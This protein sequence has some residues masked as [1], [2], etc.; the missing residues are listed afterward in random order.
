MTTPTIFDTCDPRDDVLSGAIADADFAA[1]LASVIAGTAGPEYRDPA[2]FFADTYPTRGLKD[3]LANVCGRL[4]RAGEDVGPIIRLNTAYG[5]GKTHGLI[6][7]AHLATGIANVPNIA[8]FVDEDRVPRQRIRIAAFDG[9]N[10]DPSNGRA[11]AADVLAYT[12]WGEIAYAL[13]GREGYERVRRSDEKQIAPGAETLRELFGEEPSIVLLD[14]LAVYLRKVRGISDSPPQLAAFLTSLFKAVE[15]SPQ[16]VLVYTLAIGKDG[17]ATDAYSE[18]HQHIADQLAEVESISARK[19]T[20]LDPTEEDETVQVLRRRLFKR[21]D[22]AGMRSAIEAYRKSWTANRESL[23]SEATHPKTVEA[24]QESYPLHP[25]VLETLTGKTATLGNFQRVRGMLRLLA[26]TIAHLWAEKPADARALHLHHVNPGYEPIRQ[27]IVTRLGQSAYLPAIRRD[28]AEAEGRALAEA[29]DAEHHTGLPPYATYVARTI[30]LHTLAFNERLK[31]LAPEQ[32][33]YSILSPTTDV[34]FIEEA[35]KRFI[36][37][38]AFLDDRPGAPMRFLAEANLR[39]IIRGEERNVDASEARAQLDD[40]IKTIFGGKT[41]DTIPFASGPFDVPDEIGDGRPKLALLH[42]DAINVG[43]TVDVV[44]ELIAQIYERKGAE[45]QALRSLRNHL[46]FVVAD[47]SHKTEMQRRARERLALQALKKPERLLDLAEHQQ[48]KVRELE[49]KSEHD[50]AIAIQQ[51]YRHLFYP[52]RN[53]IGTST[54]D[55]AHSALDM[56][57][58]S[59]TPGAGQDEIVRALRDQTKL[60]LSED[61]PDS[62]A[63]VRDRTTL[64]R[65]QITT[66]ALRDEFRK[67]PTLPI[68]IG[69]DIFRRGVL[70][71]VEQGEYVYRRGDL[72]FGPGDPTVS[73]EIDE[74]SVVFTMAFAK[75]TDIWPR[76]E[77]AEPTPSRPS[78]GTQ[79][80][81]PEPEAAPETPGSAEAQQAAGGAPKWS[82]EGILKEALVKLWELA[83]SKGIQALSR[84]EIRTFESSDGFALLGAVG[85]V[86]GAQKTVVLEGGYETTD[87]GTFEIKFQ[88]RVPDA[89]PVREFLQ[90]QLRAAKTKDIEIRFV[91]EFS[92]GLKLNGEAPENL[93]ERLSKFAGGAA[94]VSATGEARNE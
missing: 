55:L 47:E 18:E 91:L 37:D 5:G 65:G 40:R 49:A 4:S 19:A 29:I 58:A 24:F 17:V 15:G 92:D 94:H 75:N 86:P 26:R 82:T 51:C 56:H 36:A 28:I 13:A 3:L 10:A 7:L 14:E 52:S 73:I 21:I 81:P 2:R 63:Y 38:S 76:P 25:E 50:L 54:V 90:P 20:V 53:R 34:S 23:S 46:V 70:R 43:T 66:L 57:S 41:F 33:R 84:V 42:Y 39:Q 22:D 8:E 80:T 68:L 61:E 12:P 88:G 62:P 48:D 67:D 27:E 87:D 44:P 93:T 31:G 30:F 79:Q 72:L 16:A 9:E 45:G 69:D 11:M 77:P 60:R 78:G 74:Q 83:R 85:A 35:R 6:A 1:D 89:E 71:G 64:R 32:L 59:K